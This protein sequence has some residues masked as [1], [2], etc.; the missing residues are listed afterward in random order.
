M[1]YWS[2]RDDSNIRPLAPHASALPN[3]ATARSIELNALHSSLLL[4]RDSPRGQA[5]SYLLRILL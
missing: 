4:L 3:C 1:K 5:L 2:G